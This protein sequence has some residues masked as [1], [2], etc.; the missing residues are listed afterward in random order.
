MTNRLDEVAEQPSQIR[1]IGKVFCVAFSPNGHS[2][3]S[4]GEDGVVK[5]WDL[6]SKTMQTLQLDNDPRTYSH[7]LDLSFSPNGQHIL[8]GSND[9]R[10]YKFSINNTPLLLN[11]VLA[12]KL[13]VGFS[14]NGAYFA[15]ASARTGTHY[16]L[17]ELFD[18]QTNQALS[19]FLH[20]GDATCLAFHPLENTLA[21][22]GADRVVRFWDL[23]TQ[24]ELKTLELSFVI[25]SLTYS[26]NGTTMLI[27]GDSSHIEIR[28]TTNGKLKTNLL[29]TAKQ[30]YQVRYSPNGTMI[31]I[32]TNQNV[33]IWDATDHTRRLTVDGWAMDFSPDNQRIVVGEENGMARVYEIATQAELHCAIPHLDFIS[34]FALSSDGQR[35]ATGG[36]N[37][38]IRIWNT[39]NQ[40]ALHTIKAHTA[41]IL[42]LAFSPDGEQIASASRDKTIG[43]WDS[44]S[45]TRKQQLKLQDEPARISS[46]AFAPDGFRL[47][48]GIGKLQFWSS[49]TGK[50]LIEF[51]SP[52]DRLV[53][54]PNKKQILTANRSFGVISLLDISSQ[55][56]I[57]ESAPLASNTNCI[58]IDTTG[59]YFAV[60]TNEF[61]ALIGETI[62]GKII[63]KIVS[64][65]R[66]IVG[67]AFSPD[68]QLLATAGYDGTIQIWEISTE[69]EQLR[70]YTP[71]NPHYTIQF[72]PDATRVY[73]ASSDGVRVYATPDFV[74]VFQIAAPINT[75]KK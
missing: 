1:H 45:G 47:A 67:I 11:A 58:T 10:A 13:A 50:K 62:T 69:Q 34:T 22:G 27:A 36:V 75:R 49:Y 2:V 52:T 38:S 32:C 23:T 20:N 44:K 3:A 66:S 71:S 51:G 7:V 56:I 37:G 55:T 43:V 54:H 59:K 35:I 28:D 40:Q 29:L 64:H 41:E 33:Q 24:T 48:L 26:P 65:S 8:A 4:G 25:R 30:I 12:P 60:G 57:W 74:P 42:S 9:N 46:L 53:F 61:S 68:S 19:R 17:I 39:K 31:A 14:P 15:F 63:Q 5:L 6:S 70:Y 18:A 16:G 72:S 21:S 73:A